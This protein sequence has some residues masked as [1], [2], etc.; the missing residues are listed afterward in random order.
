[1]K[2]IFTRTSIRQYQD[3]PVEDEK[4]LEI[5]RAAMQAP[6][7]GNQQ[8]W[9][10]YVVKDKAV[11][12][13][14][15]KVTPY[16][17]CAKGAPVVIVP[18]VKTTGLRFEDYGMIDLSIAT[19]NILLEITSQGLGGVWLGIAPQE[20][21]MKAVDEIIDIKEGLRSF[22]LVALGYAAEDKVQQDRFDETRI[23]YI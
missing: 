19:E 22:A 4:I 6:S 13:K 15:S 1:M 23:H 3:K 16:A 14:L 11:I 18:C 8:P 12:E 5:L 20:D 21:K 17:G 7:A 10:F 9:E 2:E